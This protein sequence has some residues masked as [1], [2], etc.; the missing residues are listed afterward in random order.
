MRGIAIREEL[1]DEWKKRS[2]S[3]N[4]EY[5]ILTAEIS[6]AAFG[7]TPTEYKKFKIQKPEKG[8][9]ARPQTTGGTGHVFQQRYKSTLIEDD[10]YLLLS[11]A[12]LLRNP[13][14][15]GIVENAEN[16]IWSS[17]G[18]YFSP[19]GKS[20]KELVDADYV[21]GLFGTRKEFRPRFPD[22]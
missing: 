11:I 6:K 4:I 3:E 18:A 7:M 21:N 13:V 2:I 22:K 1:T 15:A 12:Y 8:K 17:I 9:L 20:D 14:R 16:Y 10:A 5:S 19:E